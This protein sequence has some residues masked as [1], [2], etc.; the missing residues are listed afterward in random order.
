MVRGCGGVS[1]SAPQSVGLAP[2]LLHHVC[3]CFR[4]C[5]GEGRRERNRSEGECGAIWV[6]RF[7]GAS[8]G[9]TMPRIAPAH[10]EMNA[11]VLLGPHMHVRTSRS[12]TRKASWP[13]L[14]NCWISS[15]GSWVSRTPSIHCIVS[16]RLYEVWEGVG[17]GMAPNEA[18]HG[19]CGAT[20]PRLTLRP[21]IAP[22]GQLQHGLG[23]DHAVVVHKLSAVQ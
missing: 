18:C 21:C 2:P 6:R 17:Q 14:T 22:A 9:P 7:V 13:T 19:V 1:V 16:T 10:T 12:C 11:A 5:L 23:D 4:P 3:I 8:H 20:Q 15:G